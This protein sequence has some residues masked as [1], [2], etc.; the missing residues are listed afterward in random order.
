M[1]LRPIYLP[2]E[3]SDDEWEW[4]RV[5]RNDCAEG[6]THNRNEITEEEQD[7]YRKS[8]NEHTRHY[9]FLTEEGPVAFSRLEWRPDGFVYP[10]VGVASWARGHGYAW[11]VMK[12]T[13]L[14]A[15]GPLKGDLLTSNK[16]IM[17][18]DFTLGWR[19][20]GEPHEGIL[21]V[22]CAWPPTFIDHDREWS[23]Q[24]VYDEI[25]RYSEEG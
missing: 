12:H 11:E 18:V 9:I 23:Q 24:Q 16:A 6:L 7:T 20:L 22:E 1:R 4:L 17:K 5:M 3:G 10:T 21:D 15:G 13:L 19:P 8:F 2:R 14:A 25:V